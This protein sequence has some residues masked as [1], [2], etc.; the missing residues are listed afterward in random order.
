MNYFQIIAISPY[1]LFLSYPDFLMK[2]NEIEEDHLT[3]KSSSFRKNNFL[4]KI[5]FLLK[6]HFSSPVS[7]QWDNNKVVLM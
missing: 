3:S 5:G 1:P 7:S 6:L 2:G 4:E